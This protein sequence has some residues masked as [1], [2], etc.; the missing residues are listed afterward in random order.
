MFHRMD[1]S[2]AAGSHA[3][4]KSSDD[5]KGPETFPHSLINGEATI[6]GKGLIEEPRCHNNG[7]RSGC[8]VALLC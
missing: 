5:S 3:S 1:H 4:Q 7:A 8:T 6:S 2:E